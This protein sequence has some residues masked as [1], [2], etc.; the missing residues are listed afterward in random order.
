M[1]PVSLPP[2]KK[3]LGQHYL[4]DGNTIRKIVA[5]LGAGPGDRVLELGPGPGALSSLL[6]AAA[7]ELLV[8]VEKDYGWAFERGRA[9]KAAGRRGGA[10]L[11]D[12]L[13]M[14]W[15][16]FGGPWKAIGNLPYN[17]ASPIMWELF[18]R[19]PHLEKAVFMVQKEVALRLVATP[20][21]KAYG[22]L[23]VWVRSFVCPKIEFLVPPAVF[24]PR[25]KVDSAVLSFAPRGATEDF[26]LLDG[27]DKRDVAALLHGVFRQRRKQLGGVLKKITPPDPGFWQTIGLDPAARP[28]NL[29][30]GDFLR[31]ARALRG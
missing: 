18:S 20:G 8:M 21:T 14:A 10:V 17:V 2:A 28:E 16:R 31:L 5:A 26:P 30:P 22:A 4:R 1:A 29:A 12:A 6:T 13:E 27:D 9:L 7:P 15:E 11:A 24:F 23:S 19:M 3:S 25:P